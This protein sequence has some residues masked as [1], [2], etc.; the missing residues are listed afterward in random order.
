MRSTVSSVLFSGH[1][2]RFVFD[3][4]RVQRFKLL[5]LGLCYAVFLEKQFPITF[6]R[7]GFLTNTKKKFLAPGLRKALTRDFC[8]CF[9]KSSPKN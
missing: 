8:F 1:D 5:D 4:V 2:K 6:P 3:L 7:P 9:A